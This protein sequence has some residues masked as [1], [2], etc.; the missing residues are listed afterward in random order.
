MARAVLLTGRPGIGKTTAVKKAVD[1]LD[2]PAGGFYTREMRAGGKRVGFE[3]VTLDGE[4]AVLAHV[5][6]KGPERLGKY[7]VNVAALEGIGVR[8]IREAVAAGHLVV[9]DEIGPMEYRS[10]RFCEAVIAALDANA[11]VLATNHRRSTPFIDSITSRDD[12]TV[13]EVTYA[14]RDDLPGQIAGM[15]ADEST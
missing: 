4:R 5:D 7:H 2:R 15:L 13:I 9:I 11:P 14:N 12:V 8:A 1:L 3:M 6:F 10:D